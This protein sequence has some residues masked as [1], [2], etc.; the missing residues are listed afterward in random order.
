MRPADPWRW[1][2]C[3][4]AALLVL[5]V[6][7]LLPRS[8]IFLLPGTPHLIPISPR[9]GGGRWLVLQP[10]PEI[11]VVPL[12]TPA[13]ETATPRP[14]ENLFEAADW[15]RSGVVVG[16]TAEGAAPVA[17]SA[18]TTKL[19]SLQVA[20]DLLG[21]TPGL[22]AGARPES[23]LASLLR[24]LR[25]EDGLRFDELKPYLHALSRSAAYADIMSRSADMFGDFLD[26][27]IMVTPRAEKRGESP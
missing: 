3:F 20:L 22:P 11:E 9:S 4:T 6:L 27:E 25:L 14:R 21:F 23:L 10:A 1:P 26:Q 2:S 13:K 5:G 16:I 18:P 17:G 7:F 8:W 12:H 19:D 15:G 24:L